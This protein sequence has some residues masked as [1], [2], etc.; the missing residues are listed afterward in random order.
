VINNYQVLNGSVLQCAGKFGADC[1]TPTPKWKH[2]ATLNLGW[3]NVDFSTRWRL[4]GAVKEDEDTD[5]QKSRIPAYNYFD[6]TVN[7]RVN[8]KYTFS[9]GMLNVFNKKPPL[10][11]RHQRR[12]LGGGQHV[13]DRLRRSGPQLLRAGVRQLLIER[14]AGR[15][16]RVFRTRPFCA[17]RARQGRV[18]QARQAW[19]KSKS[20]TQLKRNVALV[21]LGFA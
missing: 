10:D 5:I 3:K 1:D 15:R 11:R 20:P 8:D 21:P 6:E 16:P 17:R 7:M 2:V 13:L 14:L 19:L 18:V 12:H 4:I 9:L